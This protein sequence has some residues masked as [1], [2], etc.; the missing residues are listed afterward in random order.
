[1][2]SRERLPCLKVFNRKKNLMVLVFFPPKNSGK[3][4]TQVI[5]PAAFLRFLFP[6]VFTGSMD[7]KRLTLWSLS[8]TALS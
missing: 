8:L 2:G 5:S 3:D 6:S 4:Q 7:N 1:M